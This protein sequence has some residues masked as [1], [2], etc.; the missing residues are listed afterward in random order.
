VA[1]YWIFPANG[2][3]INEGKLTLAC[4]VINCFLDLLITT[5][6]IPIVMM[7]KMRLRQRIGVIILLSLGF[8]VTIAGIIRYDLLRPIEVIDT[9]N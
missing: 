5:L 7:L 4:G 6:P 8:V 1:A 3:C 2:K 9:D